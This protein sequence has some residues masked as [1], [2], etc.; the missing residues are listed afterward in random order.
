MVAV[1]MK[2]RVVQP[3]MFGNGSSHQA[4]QRVE[5]PATDKQMDLLRKLFRERDH[6]FPNPDEALGILATS[7]RG[8][9]EAIGV[10]F[11]APRKKDTTEVTEGMYRK[12]GVIYKVQRAVHG[13]GNLYAKRLVALDVPRVLKTKTV[14]HEFEYERGAIGKLTAEDK[15]SLEEAKQWGA[16]YGTCCVCG[17]QLTKESSIAAGIGPIC[18]AKF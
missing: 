15:M 7:K 14:T 13:S 1:P 3:Q 4:P 5:A 12:D 6:G 10:L 8:A 17:A 16:L 2:D 18:G 11:E 9:S